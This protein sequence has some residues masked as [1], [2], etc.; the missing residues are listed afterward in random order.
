MQSLFKTRNK[1]CSQLNWDI[2]FFIGTHSPHPPNG[3]LPYVVFVV[4]TIE[5]YIRRVQMRG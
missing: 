3:R 2:S 4:S 5:D 1:V